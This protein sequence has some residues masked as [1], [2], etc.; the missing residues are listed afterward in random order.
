[1]NP[2]KDQCLLKQV[3]EQEA[4]ARE[5]GFY[6]ENINQLI[7][8]IQSECVEI[9][10][11]W[12]KNNKIHLQE[13]VGDLIQ[14]TVSLAVF[15]NLDPHETLFKSIQKFQKRYNKVVQLARRDGYDNLQQQ[16]FELLMDY[17]KQAKQNSE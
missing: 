13:E 10:E 3:E 2:P 1:M 12:K 17:W 16:P 11:A 6:W 5:F 4:Q 14:A 7:E 9:Q 15:C 8:Q